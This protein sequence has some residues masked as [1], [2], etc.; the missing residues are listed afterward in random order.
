M[1]SAGSSLLAVLALLPACG[2]ADQEFDGAPA[3]LR[4]ARYVDAVEYLSTEGDGGLEGWS[5]ARQQLRADFDRICGDTFCEG[6]Y[7]DLQPL[8]LRCA[9]EAKS[10]DLS[11]CAWSIAGSS[12]RVSA[13]TGTLR[14]SGKLYRCALPVA[15][16][17]D[18][19]V[20]TLAAPGEVPPL[21]RPLPGTARSTFDALAD[22]GL[23]H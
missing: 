21:R 23:G 20:Q 6:D 1:R 3:D 22:C 17:I 15:G 14:I 16:T 4:A 19:L 5:V 8:E 2:G 18:A 12:G 13:S 11:A 7:G 9:V 10:G